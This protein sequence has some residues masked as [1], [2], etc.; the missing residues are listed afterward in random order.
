MRL[1]TPGRFVLLGALVAC[2]PALP[3]CRELEG[4]STAS[5]EIYRGTIVPADDIRRGVDVDGDEVDDILG[6]ETS[7]EMTLRVEEFQTSNVARVTTSDGLLFDAPLLS[8]DASWHDTLSGLN[9][10]SGRLRSGLYFVR[11]SPDAPGELAGAE[12]V[13]VLSLM[14]DGSVE[15]RLISGADRLYGLFR[16][17]KVSGSLPDAGSDVVEDGGAEDAADH[18]DLIGGE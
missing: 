1:V 10:P 11:A 5:G 14:V 15:M 2:L 18:S 7:M 17:R 12:L 4:F 16:L 8:I 6:P 3:G 13:V 9:F